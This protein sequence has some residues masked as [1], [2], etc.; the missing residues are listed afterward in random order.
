MMNLVS[1]LIGIHKLTC[2]NFYDFLIPYLKPQQ[3]DVPS[4]LA[5]AAQASHDLVPPDVIT[6]VVQAIADHFVWSNSAVEVVTAGLNGLREI[7]SRCPLAMPEALLHSLLE[8]YK[9][10]RDKSK[11]QNTHHN[12]FF[13]LPFIYGDT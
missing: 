10:N 5:Y 12:Y 11:F 2:L 4:I 6:P 3:R 13:C 8:D 9:N 1:R 7:C